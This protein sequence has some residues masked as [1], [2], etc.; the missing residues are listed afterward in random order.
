MST[1]LNQAAPMVYV[2]SE[3]ADGPASLLTL[4]KNYEHPVPQDHRRLEAMGV[5][6]TSSYLI[7]GALTT[8]TAHGIVMSDASGAQSAV[9]YSLRHWTRRELVEQAAAARIRE[10]VAGTSLPKD[11]G[12]VRHVNLEA[13]IKAATPNTNRYRLLL[14]VQQKVREVGEG[15][16]FII[17]EDEVQ[18]IGSNT[19]HVWKRE[20]SRLRLIDGLTIHRRDNPSLTDPNPPYR[21]FYKKP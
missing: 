9:M 19:A 17:S 7:G 21:G 1:Q 20:V 5:I 11:Y 6:D 10:L 18:A 16:E 4:V 12:S 2:V 15:N 3:L 8:L 13:A 14:L